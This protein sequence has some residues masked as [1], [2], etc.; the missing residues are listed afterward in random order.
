MYPI[1]NTLGKEQ[2]CSLKV[3]HI[4]DNHRVKAGTWTGQAR[5]QELRSQIFFVL[6]RKQVHPKVLNRVCFTMPKRVV[7]LH[8]EYYLGI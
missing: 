3:A 4:E 1:S 6:M 8:K 2:G 7:S 5:P